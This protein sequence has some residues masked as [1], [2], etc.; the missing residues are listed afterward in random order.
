VC[1]VFGLSLVCFVDSIW[2][3]FVDLV[4]IWVGPGFVFVISC[5]FCRFFFI[6]LVG[7]HVGVGYGGIR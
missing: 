4:R 5:S 2:V 6:Y 7:I 3:L 1:L